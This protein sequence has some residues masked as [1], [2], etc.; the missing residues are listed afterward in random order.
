VVEAVILLLT[1]FPIILK[2]Q[3][4]TSGMLLST[5]YVFIIPPAVVFYALTD[6]SRFFVLLITG[7]FLT[8]I[9]SL[10]F[11]YTTIQKTTHIPE[12]FTTYRFNFST[13]LS[14]LGLLT[15]AVYISIITFNGLPSFTALNLSN[16]Y[17]VRAD[18]VYGSI[19]L[20]Y[21][22]T[23]QSNVINPFLIIWGL[24][25]EN[26]P[27]IVTGISLQTIL[28]LY[29]GHK[30]IL[31][32]SILVIMYYLLARNKRVF[33]GMLKAVSLTILISLGIYYLSK[34][35]LIPS[36]FIRRLFFVPAQLRELYIEFFS[37]NPH[38][39]LNA[40]E[41]GALWSAPYTK[42]LPNIIG[43]YY[44]SGSHANI[45]YIASG[46]A[47]FGIIGL[48]VFSVIFGTVLATIEYASRPI[49][50]PALVSGILIIPIWNV[51]STRLSTTL[52]THGLG[53]ALLLVLLLRVAVKNSIE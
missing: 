2:Y 13:L 29:T 37:Q 24:Y 44:L 26:S 3:E 11:I 28:F 1:T 45:G 30:S 53:F 22:I 5:L 51:D 48:V 46:Y 33:T 6:S 20:A 35:L 9:V 42:S 16:V 50:A 36:I 47:D 38:T 40:S 14:G 43:D 21:L 7:G 49:K 15:I 27:L 32:S 25:S 23:W 52:F 8:T 31:F 17:L 39:K 12:G 4:L 41:L 18:F 19:I 10:N 34:V